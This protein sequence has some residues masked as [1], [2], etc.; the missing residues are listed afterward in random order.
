M[1]AILKSDISVLNTEHFINAVLNGSSNVYVALSKTSEWENENL[2]P[3]P[4]D[5][6]N[7]ENAFR[8]AIIGI[9]RITPSNLA[10]MVPRINWTAG[11]TFA[12]LDLSVEAAERATN[13]FCLTSSNMVFQC[14]GAG[15]GLT[16][17][18]PATRGASVVTADGYTWRYL[19]DLPNAMNNA[20]LLLDA[21][22]PVPYSIRGEYPGG[23]LTSEQFNFGD[24][25]ANRVLGAHR[26]L[27]ALTFADETPEIPYDIAFRQ[28]GLLYDPKDNSDAFIAGDK[29]SAVGFNTTSGEL[30]YLDN[31]RRVFREVG[32]SETVNLILVF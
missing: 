10:V 32:Q 12:P 18:E 21:W 19:Y 14:I 20:G 16:S 1:A 17:Q 24:V 15:L 23:T 3:T 27:V 9:K 8:S 28:V 22:M 5:S 29:Y 31:K 4:T 6:M 26:I 25:F 2:P 13:Y 11:T 30:V 7:D